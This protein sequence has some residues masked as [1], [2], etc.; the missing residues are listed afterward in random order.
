MKK[1]KLHLLLLGILT[2]P[3]MVKGQSMNSPIESNFKIKKGDH[4]TIEFAKQIEDY[5]TP[6][7]S[8][9]YCTPSDLRQLVLRCEVTE[10]SN[11]NIQFDFNFERIFHVKKIGE[12]GDSYFDLPNGQHSPISL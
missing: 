12:Y 7:D 11:D 1:T 3:L 9:D 2:M 4:F 8:I 6:V 10:A 5:S